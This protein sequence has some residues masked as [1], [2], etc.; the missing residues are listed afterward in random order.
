MSPVETI[1]DVGSSRR[2]YG[3][4]GATRKLLKKLKEFA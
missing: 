4:G 3:F 1:G 2:S